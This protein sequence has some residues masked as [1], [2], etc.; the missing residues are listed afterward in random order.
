MEELEQY[1]YYHIIKFSLG[2]FNLILMKFLLLV[3]SGLESGS[4]R[5]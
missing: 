1:K 3:W 5:H 2:D 4:T